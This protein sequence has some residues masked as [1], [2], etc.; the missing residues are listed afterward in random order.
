M[1]D[2]AYAKAQAVRHLGPVRSGH[3]RGRERRLHAYASPVSTTLPL[4]NEER[5]VRGRVV[6]TTKDKSNETAHLTSPFHRVHTSL[7]GEGDVPGWDWPH[8]EVL[9]L[10]VAARSSV[11]RHASTELAAHSSGTSTA[12]SSLG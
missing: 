9:S 3:R 6:E 7:L 12:T 10:L 4:N 1:G 11:R 2:R 8:R 5:R